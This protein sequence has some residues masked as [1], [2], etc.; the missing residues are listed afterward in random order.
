MENMGVKSSKNKLLEIRRW[1]VKQGK[2][3][4]LSMQIRDFAVKQDDSN[5]F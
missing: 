3:H 4:S 2:A 1:Y 5:Y